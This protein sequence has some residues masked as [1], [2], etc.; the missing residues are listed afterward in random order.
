M[1][2]QTVRQIAPRPALPTSPETEAGL[3]ASPTIQRTDKDQIDEIVGRLAHRFTRDQISVA[4]LT[5]RVRRSYNSFAAVRIRSFVS[6]F[7]ERGVRRS[8]ETPTS[9]T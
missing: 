5:T 9:K 2:E 4:E 6:I 3:I 7:V 8:I 1:P